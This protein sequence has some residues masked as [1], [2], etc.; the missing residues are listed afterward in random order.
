MTSKKLT[1]SI[2]HQLGRQEAKRRVEEQLGRLRK[3]MGGAMATLKEQWTGDTLHF[4]ASPGGAAISG[5]AS[6]EDE[7]IELEVMLP[8]LFAMLGSSIRHRIER[9][10]QKLLT[11][12]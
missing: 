9:E 7:K 8:W 10:S 2:P 11:S 12:R 5:T 3:E 6:F 1:M 4:T